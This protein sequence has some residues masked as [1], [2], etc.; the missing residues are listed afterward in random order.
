MSENPARSFGGAQHRVDLSVSFCYQDW[1]NVCCGS[2]AGAGEGTGGR[3]GGL[4]LDQE[5]G[6]GVFFVLRRP[7]W[8]KRNCL[9]PEELGRGR[10]RTEDWGGMGRGGAEAGRWG[11]RRVGQKMRLG[12]PS[13]SPSPLPHPL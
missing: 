8:G 4:I 7:T 13:P 1:D 12:L 9:L 10:G 11:A 6:G 2:G 5:G 3:T